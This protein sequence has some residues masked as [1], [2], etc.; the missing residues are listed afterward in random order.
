MAWDSPDTIDD[1]SYV[2]IDFARAD[3]EYIQQLAG[4]KK[5]K[6]DLEKSGFTAIAQGD[7]TE[8]AGIWDM[9]AVLLA[10]LTGEMLG[11]GKSMSGIGS[12]M[13]T[14]KT[15]LELL[16]RFQPV[17]DHCPWPITDDGPSLSF[18]KVFQML[19]LTLP[20]GGGTILCVANR[21]AW[22]RLTN[23]RV[24][25]D[26]FRAALLEQGALDRNEIGSLL[27]PRPPKRRI[28]L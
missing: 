12:D 1:V 10:G 11:F 26:G 3:Q 22:E 4:P 28:T 14:C 13:R 7:I 5:S 6:A 24:R 21:R 25:F 16:L 2:Y 23:Q 20:E 15:Y 8:P 9:L 18:E 27:G 17:I 19:D